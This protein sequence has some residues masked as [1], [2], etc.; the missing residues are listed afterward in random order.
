MM[1]G[2]GTTMLNLS[3][4][5]AEQFIKKFQSTTAWLYHGAGAA[6]VD[7]ATLGIPKP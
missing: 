5:E 6:K 4:A 7:P 2:R 3:G 1:T